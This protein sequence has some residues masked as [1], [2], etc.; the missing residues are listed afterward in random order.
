MS[1]SSKKR[2]VRQI[3]KAFSGHR[4]WRRQVKTHERILQRKYAGDMSASAGSQCEDGERKRQRKELSAIWTNEVPPI[5]HE[6][7]ASPGQPLDRDT[8]AFMEPRFGHDFS[9][10][11]VHVDAKAEE[12]A[13]SINASAYTVNQHIVLGK[14]TLQD[15][16]SDHR[17]VLAHELVH[18]L[19]QHH[20]PDY[21]GTSLGVESSATKAEQEANH[22]ATQ[23]AVPNPNA[24]VIARPS[25]ITSPAV[26]RYESGEH[27]QFGANAGEVER[28]FKVNG[29]ELTYG[30][31]IAIGG[32][33]L[34][35]PTD[36][37]RIPAT[38]LR[39]MVELIHRQRTKGVASVTDADW[40]R[41]IGQ[42][43][44]K[45]AANNDAHF[46]PDYSGGF[47]SGSGD[48]KSRWFTLHK[49]A[50]F[51]ALM[52]DAQG[53]MITNAF[54]DHFLTDAF[55]AGHL[56]SKQLVY[57]KAVDRLKNPLKFE[58]ALATLVLKDPRGQKL[59]DYL[60]SPTLKP[61]HWEP[62]S[63]DSLTRL[64]DFVRKHEPEGFY[65]LFVK[66]VH[67]HLN[68]GITTGNAVEVTSIHRM[69]EKPW[70][71]S[72]DKTL[73]ASPDTLKYGRAAVAQSRANILE[74]MGQ[75]NIDYEAFAQRVWN[76]VPIPTEAG[77]KTINDAVERFTDPDQ[78]AT[79]TAF[80]DVT[81]ENLDTVI[82]KLV[83]GP[84]GLQFLKKKEPSGNGSAPQ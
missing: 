61:W 36:I 14:R 1:F 68:Q 51:L 55:S 11:R 79:V 2:R 8:R 31:I 26:Q 42:R 46:A 57:K 19:Q 44:L 45:L 54:A 39:A 78:P 80:A 73:N 69:S 60:A 64:F 28:T 29:V 47:R 62:M 33:L 75:T 35:D 65:S 24:S 9:R 7:L 18:T 56:F 50:L 10:V 25:A 6:V 21:N 48:H 52:R 72:G 49:R 84:Y 77:Q 15:D 17:F 43:Y 27:A 76:H 12:S 22:I 53:A 34:E 67:D 70:M 66:L 81:L 82:E 40:I 3:E 4:D 71:L 16:T 13:Q 5:V 63:V 74:A 32:D 59:N 58:G 30:D 37:Y 83:N 20:L 23:I 41:V 38:E